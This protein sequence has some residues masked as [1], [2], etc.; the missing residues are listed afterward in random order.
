MD[1]FKL[2]EHSSRMINKPQS[3]AG[4]LVGFEWKH[5]NGFSLE[6]K[7]INQVSVNTAS[8][9]T[10]IWRA[11]IEWDE[12][13]NVFDSCF[14]RILTVGSVASGFLGDGMTQENMITDVSSKASSSF[15]T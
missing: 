15:L 1:G 12:V 3:Q 13:E 9:G 14:T 4:R 5:E 7:D 2:C 6:D 11:S 8:S 10:R